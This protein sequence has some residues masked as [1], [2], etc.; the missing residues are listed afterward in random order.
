MH[1]LRQYTPS[2]ALY[3]EKL[4]TRC[5]DCKRGLHSKRMREKHAK[6]RAEREAFPGWRS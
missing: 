4:T 3:A 2:R 1:E 6:A 5:A